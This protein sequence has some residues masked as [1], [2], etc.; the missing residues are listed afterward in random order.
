MFFL[1]IAL[2][3]CSDDDNCV[4]PV[5]KVLNDAVKARLEAAADSI[6]KQD[7]APGLLAVF[8]VDGEQD[9]VITRGTGDLSTGKPISVENFFRIASNTKMF[10]GTAVLIQADKGKIDLNKPISFYLPELNVPNGD[11]ITVRMLGNMT[12]GLNNYSDNQ[13]FWDPLV[14]AN[15]QIGVLPDSLLAN[16]FRHPVSFEPGT[17]W[18]Y[19][20]T[21][22]VLLG[23]LLEKVTGKSAD[24][25]IEETVIHPLGLTN[26][27][28]GATFFQSTPYTH[29]YTRA[30]GELSDATNWNPS[31]AYTAGQ[32]VSNVHDMKIWIKSYAEGALISDAMKAERFTWIGGHYGFC[33]MK[34]GDWIGHAGT[35][36]G[37]NS[38]V[39]YNTVKKIT[40]V[41]YC[42]MDTG[43]PIEYFGDA[44]RAVFDE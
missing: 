12:S 44:F 15:F 17:K 14:A 31:W 38:H 11:R 3:S 29:G 39:M 21:N 37:F 9:I 1:G 20:N 40:M 42:N 33:A 35:M 36:F 16:S 30:L 19:C 43:M 26:T 7:R 5:N 18:E 6:F 22:T 34:A 4:A 28:W 27:Y 2:A 41:I 25:V 8:S 10:T 32:L 13:D 23:K 24:D